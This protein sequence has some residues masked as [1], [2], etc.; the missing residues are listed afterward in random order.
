MKS[1]QLHTCFLRYP[2]IH[3]L[4]LIFTIFFIMAFHLYPMQENSTPVV[5]ITVLNTNAI[6]WNTDVFYSIHV[7]DKEDGNSNYDEIESREVL[8]KVSYL[9]DSTKIPEYK[10]KI[11]QEEEPKAISLMKSSTCF[12]CHSSRS[13]VIGPAFNKI[14]S[15]YNNTDS[16]VEALIAK[17]MNGSKGVWGEVQMPSNIDLKKEEIKEVIRWILKNNLN[18]NEFYQSGLKGT[19]R[20]PE[21]SMKDNNRGVVVITS[22]Y[23][24][25][26]ISGNINLKKRGSQTLVLKPNL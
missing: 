18:A 19:F 15:R 8:L 11:E 14:A 10:N 2:P 20:I 22:S 12:N 24:D 26:G 3:I 1:S 17:V 21:G 25:H 5:R 7:V 13:I 9:P 23:I 16:N 6:Q 4:I